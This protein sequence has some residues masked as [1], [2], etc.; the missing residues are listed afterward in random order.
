MYI[1]VKTLVEDHSNSEMRPPTQL[2][3]IID[4]HNNLMGRDEL[5]LVIKQKCDKMIKR[6]ALGENVQA[7]HTT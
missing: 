6:R 4:S 5:Y 7:L 1:E 2:N 3:H